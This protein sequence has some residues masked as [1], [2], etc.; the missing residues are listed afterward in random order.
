M[1]RPTGAAKPRSSARKSASVDKAEEETAQLWVEYKDLH[2]ADARERLI[3]HYSPL[4]KYVAGRVFSGLP[5][6]IEFSDLVSYGV[7]GL[8]DAIEK[9]DLGRGIKFETYAIARIK[10]AIIDE[11]RADDWVPRSVR[12]KAR[13]IEK[14]YVSLESKL[15]REPTD[16]EVAGE[17]CIELDEYLNL[18]GNLTPISIVALD[19]LWTVTGDRPDRI[20]FAETI[21]DV[22][23]KDPSKTFEVEEI[24]DMIASAIN[25]L[26]ERERTVV[27]LYYFEG[28]TMREIGEVLS[29]T[30]SRVCQIHTKA[31]LRLRARLGNALGIDYA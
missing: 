29:V 13:E 17:L 15:R 14:A 19:E 10:G 25:H 4:V 30:E 27:S 24:K 26:P 20:S 16:E 22:K 23:V 5:S 7:F 31:I 12:L 2:S 8:L 18:L 21:E 9:Y 1:A 11:L 28:L 3:L 6:S